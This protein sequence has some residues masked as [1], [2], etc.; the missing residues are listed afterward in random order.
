MANQ[1]FDRGYYGGCVV[2]GLATAVALIGA[3]LATLYFHVATG[4][5]GTKTMCFYKLCI[6]LVP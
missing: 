2:G 1:D 6:T 4:P 5:F 3:T